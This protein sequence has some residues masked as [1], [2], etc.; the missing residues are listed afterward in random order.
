MKLN[1][2]YFTSLAQNSLGGGRLMGYAAGL[3]RIFTPILIDYNGVTC[4]L[5]LLAWHG[6]FSVRILGIKKIQVGR[7]LEKG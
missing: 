7:D 2:P 5:K 3:G 6:T 1:S 4:S